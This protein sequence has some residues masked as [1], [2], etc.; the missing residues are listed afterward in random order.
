MKK[1]SR[2]MMMLVVLSVVSL[3]GGCSP[4]ALG[5]G[6]AIG[7]VGGYLTSLLHPI[8]TVERTCFVEGVEVDCATIGKCV[9]E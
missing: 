1:F 9:S 2:K 3:V 8:T 5:V 7:V 6:G 4:I